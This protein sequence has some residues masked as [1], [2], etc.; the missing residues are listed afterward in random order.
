VRKEKTGPSFGEEE[1]GAF[2]KMGIP[3]YR[4]RKASIYSKNKIQEEE[5]KKIKKG[6]GCVGLS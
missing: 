2:A 6:G 5:K 3:A 4:E 1:A